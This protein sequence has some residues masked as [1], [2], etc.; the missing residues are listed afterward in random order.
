[1]AE[2]LGTSVTGG[3]GGALVKQSWIQAVG[4]GVM[5]REPGG[6]FEATI[7]AKNENTAFLSSTRQC[8][9]SPTP[10]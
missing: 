8:P 10:R 3:G 2:N 7:V 5:L 4:Q 1:M 6:A 9:T